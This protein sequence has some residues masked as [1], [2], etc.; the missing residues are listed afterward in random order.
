M[1]AE[2][3][4]DALTPGRQKV[5]IHYLT[6]SKY[7]PVPSGDRHVG[8]RP[9]RDDMHCMMSNSDVKLNTTYT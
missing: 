8:L 7:Y 5:Y 4:F 6:A 1:E 3:A 9:P 2:A